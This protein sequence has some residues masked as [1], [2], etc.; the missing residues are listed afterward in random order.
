GRESRVRC[1]CFYPDACK[2]VTGSDDGTVYIWDRETD[3]VELL[4]GHTSV[5]WGVDVSRDGKMIV[6]GSEDK[7]VRVWNGESGETM[8]VFEGHKDYVTSVQFSADSSRVVSGSEDETVRVWSVET[9]SEVPA[10][11]ERIKCHGWVRCVR[12]SPS[13][14]RI[15]SGATN[16]IQIWDAET[17]SGILSIKN[18]SVYSLA[19]TADSTHVIGGRDGEVTIWNAHDG[20]QLRTWK[21][22][23]YAG[24][25]QLSLIGTHLAT[26]NWNDTTAFVFDISTGEP[27]TTFKHNQDVNLN[28]ISISYSPSGQFVAT[29]CG[30]GKI[31]LW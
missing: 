27:V 16:C 29:G 20:E 23:D 5:V 22:Y 28:G 6:S 17:G 12:Y 14:D 18:S 24:F 31:Y 11:D 21:A 13:G 8:N 1:V 3:A 15:A 30:D 26:S 9:G 19:W 4:R 2:I 7:T 10:V 25:I